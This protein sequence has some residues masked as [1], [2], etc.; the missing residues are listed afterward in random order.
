MV[1]SLLFS[2]PFSSA[3]LSRCALAVVTVLS[4]SLPSRAFSP[5]R[6]ANASSSLRMSSSSF[7]VAQFPCLSDNYGYL[8]HD[9]STGS[10]CAIDTPCAKTY[11]KELD[12]RGWTLTHIFNTHHHS[13]HQGGNLELKTDG[14]T[15]IGPSNEKRE[16]AG[17]DKAVSGGDVVEFGSFQA[18]VLDAGGHTHGHIAFYFPN[19]ST[20]FT[21][22]CLF[23]L[24]CGR[25][26]EG[27]PK[28]FWS[29][30]E[31]LRGLPDDT[32]VYCAHEY[33]ESNGKFALSVE[34]N[35]QDLVDRMAIVKSKRARNEPTVPSLLGEEKKANPFLRVDMSDEIRENVG[36]T[37]S[38][39]AADAFGKVR[40]AKDNF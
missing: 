23:S 1:N 25:M 8:L 33:T 38:D 17:I 12:K 18:N 39:S 34:P 37:D 15:I 5:S 22:D 7:T 35:N 26:F 31:R 27:N 20:V 21:G 11:K 16:I 19:Q 10:T 6:V 3:R 14:V 2:R 13:D 30:L 24:G 32:L 29:S 9:P 40:R 4:P 28:Q 36:V